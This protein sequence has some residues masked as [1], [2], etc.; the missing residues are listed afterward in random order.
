MTPV[1]INPR[2]RF[3]SHHSGISRCNGTGD[4]S[5]GIPVLKTD[6]TGSRHSQIVP[7]CRRIVTPRMRN[8]DQYRKLVIVS[9][10]LRK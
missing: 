4:Q 6:Q 9:V 10:K 1:Q 7:D 3:P 5:I 2:P 8:A